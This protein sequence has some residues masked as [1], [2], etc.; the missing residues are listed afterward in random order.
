MK[1]GKAKEEVGILLLGEGNTSLG[2]Q[3]CEADR[4]DPPAPHPASGCGSLP[5]TG[6]RAGSPVWVT[7]PTPQLPSRD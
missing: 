5:S 4:S 1:P 6:P 3:P 2:T 7:D